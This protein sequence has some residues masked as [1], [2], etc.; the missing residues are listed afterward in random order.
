MIL[1][2][3]GFTAQTFKRA[4][5]QMRPEMARAIEGLMHKARVKMTALA[6]GPV[7]HRRTGRTAQAISM[8]K[9]TSEITST[10]VRGILTHR[11]LLLN[12]HEHGA[13]IPSHLVV[14][15]RRQALRFRSKGG[16][17]VR[18]MH[19]STTGRSAGKGQV[20]IP[21]FS[22]P[23]RPIA[24]PVLNAL[25]PELHARIFLIVQQLLEREIAS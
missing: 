21:G 13:T 19:R 9:V 3:R 10:S 18:F 8:G 5:E 1:Q 24:M 2:S 12:I 4:A 20:Q 14:P 17:F 15:K 11:G 25:E 22:L 7:L 6:S 23:A 16:G